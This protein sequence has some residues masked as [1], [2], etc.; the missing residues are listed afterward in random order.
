M[1]EVPL[2]EVAFYAVEDADVA[3]QLTKK[4]KI[5]LKEQELDKPFYDID[6]P[7][8]SVLIEMEKNGSY[9]DMDFLS[10][11]S[12]NFNSKLDEL[13]EQIYTIS[14]NEFNINS[15]KQLAEVLFDQL[16]L[17][18]IKKRSTDVNVLNVLKKYFGH[19]TAHF[20]V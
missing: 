17:K 12:K 18:M 19:I 10:D 11:L 2:S 16:E 9:V 5:L 13:K 4:F 1:N 14:E 7:L 8:V 6:M 15:P 3:F 20:D